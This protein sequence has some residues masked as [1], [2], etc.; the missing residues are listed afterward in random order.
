MSSHDAPDPNPSV[1][2][3]RRFGELNDVSKPQLRR[4][5]NLDHDQTFQAMAVAAMDTYTPDGLANFGQFKAVVLKVVVGSSAADGGQAQE[6]ERGGWFTSFF[7]DSATEE[8]AEY[9]QIVEIK[10]RVPE[11]HSMLPMPNAIGKD[12]PKEDQKIIRIDLNILCI[13]I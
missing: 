1:V 13:L 9:G 4:S 10:A 12:A 3:E 2:T 6:N 11:V 5:V 7:G 8:M